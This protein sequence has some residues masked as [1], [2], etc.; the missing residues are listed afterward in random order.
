ME[1]S[2]K[3]GLQTT[4]WQGGKNNMWKRKA[5]RV[6][7][8]PERD[9]S[10]ENLEDGSFLVLLEQNWLCVKAAAE[11]LQKRTEMMERWQQQEV[12]VK[13]TRWAEEIPQKSQKEKTGLK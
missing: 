11:G 13:E 12:Q 3:K 6:T 1:K 10:G 2:A 4:L 8:V 7:D 9:R 5:G